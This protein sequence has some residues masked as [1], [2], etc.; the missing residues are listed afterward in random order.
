MPASLQAAA[1]SFNGSR[2]NGVDLMHQSVSAELYIPNPSWC[3]LVMT[4]YFIP[5]FFAMATQW[6]ASNFTGLNCGTSLAYCE[7]GIRMSF[8]I[9][10][11]APDV[12][13]PS[14]DPAAC[15]YS[16]Q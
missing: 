12:G 13:L 5:A 9:H 6:R 4:M 8:M 14:H 16:P 1:N 11:P 15:A 10:S 3:L 7:S 2:P